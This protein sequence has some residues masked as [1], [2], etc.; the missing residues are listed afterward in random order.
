MIRCESKFV[1]MKGFLKMKEEGSN[2]K[3]EILDDHRD[4][5]FQVKN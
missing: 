3:K 5:T 4:K 2:E 1:K